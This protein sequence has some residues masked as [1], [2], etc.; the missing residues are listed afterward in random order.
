MLCHQAALHSLAADHLVLVVLA[1]QDLQGGLDDATAQA[2]HQVEGGLCSGQHSASS[3][4]SDTAAEVLQA[5]QG[6]RLMLA[7][8]G[9]CRAHTWC[10]AHAPCDTQHDADDGNE[11][12][13]I[14]GRPCVGMSLAD[15]SQSALVEAVG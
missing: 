4:G 9:S 14:T 3:T 8:S 1:S 12:L 13:S 5:A 11:W 7:S 2:Q 10:R 15:A 6:T